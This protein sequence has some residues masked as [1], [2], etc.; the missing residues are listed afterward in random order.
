[1]TNFYV[2]AIFTLFVL[3]MLALDL[4][5]FHRR[6][7]AVSFREAAI[8]T[9]FW[10]TVAMAFNVGLLIWRGVQPGL[11]FLTAYILEKSLSL[12]NVF[13][14]AAIFSTASVPQEYQHKVLFWGVVGAIVTRAIFIFAGLAL[15]SRIHWTLYV[16]GVFLVVAGI[17][18]LREKRPGIDPERSLVIRLARKL[19]PIVDRYEGEVFFVRRNSKL[20]ATPLLL[21]L[22]MVES[23]DLV[24]ATDSIP[25]VFAVTRD[26]LIV[27]TS[28][29]LAVMGLRAMYLLVARAMA[30]LRY[31][32]VG[33]SL[34]LVF[35]GTKMTIDPIYRIPVWVTLSTLSLI[36]ITVVV[37]S[38]AAERYANQPASR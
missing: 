11:E 36:L 15:V 35:V 5:I 37:A 30:R 27:Y 17:R 38:Q 32:R 24:F 25:A 14:F 20:L 26:P 13:V 3:G 16:F 4:A 28:N 31:L 19:F 33:L 12:D 1:M 18:L 10:V 21:V 8:W 7:H 2:L 29:I 22:V 9:G 34:I 23:A 6:A